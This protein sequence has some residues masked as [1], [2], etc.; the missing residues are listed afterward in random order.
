MDDSKKNKWLRAFPIDIQSLYE[1]A[2][3]PLPH[4]A[5]RWWWCWGGIAGFLF[6]LQIVTGLLLAIYYRAEPGVAYQTVKYITEEARYGHFIRSIHHWGATFMIIFLFLHVLRVFIT[7]SFRE[8]RWGA[9]MI[10]ACLLGLTLGLSFTGYSLV[11]NQTS[12]WAITVTSNIVSYIPLIGQ[13]LK[14]F[15]LA[16]SEI[17][18]ATLSRMYAMHVQIL[19]AFVFVFGLAHLFFVRLMGMYIPGNQEDRKR[20][21]DLT[22]RE[23]VYHFYPDHLA[24]ELAVFLYLFLIICL[25]SIALPAPLGVPADPTVTPEH[26]KPEWYFYSFFHL[27]KLIPGSSGILVM[28]LIG[29]L[30]FFWPILDHYLLQRIDVRLKG[31]FEIGLIFGFIILG[32]Y[33]L[34]TLKEVSY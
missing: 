2:D 16:G 34:W 9:W 17:N 12:Y 7:G 11:Y 14:K 10:G 25:L 24:S 15:F 33:L 22:T 31:R 32:L 18:S 4:S 3:E 29:L 1:K 5:K 13:F 27:L 26:I 6:L 8:Y 30:F 19:P 21:S 23:G 28:G 20:E